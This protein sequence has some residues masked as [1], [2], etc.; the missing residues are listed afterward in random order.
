MGKG[1]KRLISVRGTGESMTRVDPLVSLMHHDPDRSWISD[2]NPDHPKGMQP[3]HI[4]ALNG[5]SCSV[6]I[7]IRERGTR[8]QERL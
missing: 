4:F 2:P 8:L 1:L 3:E 5:G 6:A 7:R